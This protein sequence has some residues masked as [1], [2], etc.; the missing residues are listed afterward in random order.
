MS[1]SPQPS[2]KNVD[3]H[4]LHEFR[5]VGTVRIRPYEVDR[6]SEFLHG[7][8]QLDYAVFWGL[9]GKTLAEVRAEYE[10]LVSREAYEVLV[11]EVDG[12]PAFDL[13]RYDPEFD[14]LGKLYPTRDGDCGIHLIVAPRPKNP[15]P[16]FT[17]FMFRASLQRVFA[18]SHVRRV[19]VEP[20]IRNRKMFMLCERLGFE[21]DRVVELSHKTAQMAMLARDRYE[22]LETSPVVKRRPAM[23]TIDR[24][25]SPHQAVSHLTKARWEKANRHLVAKA[26]REFT[27][28]RLLEATS[29]GE[30]SYRVSNGDAVVYRF[31]AT[32]LPL[33][34]LLVDEASIRVEGSPDAPIDAIRFLQEF[35][36]PLGI[37]DALLPHY[38]EE[39]M[40][41]LQGA[42]FKM[43]K[44]NLS[45][46]ELAHADFQ[47]IEQSMTEGHPCFV[48]NNGRIGFD[49]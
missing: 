25:V 19:V 2:E 43:A 5:E 24:P 38:L 37:R 6:D 22:A 23:N 11:G 15:V 33:E 47:T 1:R 21:L 45:A 31:E 41:T 49:S 30:N 8:G 7:W 13:E 3:G 14:E 16:H 10:Q 44:N 4:S 20:D 39:V 42:A 17:W 27:H 9:Q 29:T 48:A 32:E 46:A 26:I 35:R 12:N 18:E 40:S 28:E 34:D 36:K